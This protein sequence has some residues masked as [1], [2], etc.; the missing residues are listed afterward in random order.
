MSFGSIFY[1]QKAPREEKT[2]YVLQN[3]LQKARN[4]NLNTSFLAV[5]IKL[6]VQRTNLIDVNLDMSRPHC[7]YFQASIGILKGMQFCHALMF[8]FLMI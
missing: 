8:G 6:F 2:F 5:F 7:S 4:F 3:I 1:F